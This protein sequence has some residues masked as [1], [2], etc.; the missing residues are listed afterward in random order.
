MKKYMNRREAG[1]EL[2]WHLA[3]YAKDKQSL[4][5]ALARGGVPVAYEVAKALS[6]PL[7]VYLVR[8]LGVP[9]HEE[10]AMG[11]LAGE[12]TLFLNEKVIQSLSLPKAE[13]DKVIK[14]EK[15]ELQRRDALYRGSRPFPSLEGKKVILIDDGIATGATVRAA[16][17]GI[18]EHKPAKIILAV[19]VAAASTVRELNSQVDELIC[20]LQPYDFR[21][22]GFWYVDFSQTT[23]EEVIRLCG[24]V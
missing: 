14:A 5:L 18:K 19:P 12:H 22:V 8:K 13:I 7:E 1:R 3:P 10:Y 20:P 15:N 6:I 17:R 23:D 2:A 4:V 21:A 16:L 9:G 11:A 24:G